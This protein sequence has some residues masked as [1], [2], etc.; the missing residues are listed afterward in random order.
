MGLIQRS[1]L[2]EIDKQEIYYCEKGVC[3]ATANGELECEDVVDMQN[4]PLDEVTTPLVLDST[5]DVLTV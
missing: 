3:V 5:L 1:P 2:Q 4:V